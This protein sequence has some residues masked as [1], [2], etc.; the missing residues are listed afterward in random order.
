M[1]HLLR[2]VGSVLSAPALRMHKLL[3]E[4]RRRRHQHISLWKERT[5]EN[6]GLTLNILSDRRLDVIL[7]SYSVC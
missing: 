7:P 4:W 3:L 2:L 1:G 5:T 6:E